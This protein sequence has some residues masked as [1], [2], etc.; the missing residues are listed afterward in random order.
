MKDRYSYPVITDGNDRLFQG[1]LDRLVGFDNLFSVGRLGMFC[2]VPMCIC[3][4]QCMKLVDLMARYHRMDRNE[5]LGSY[6]GLR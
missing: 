5:R 6:Y 1:L 4:N 2:Y 3:I